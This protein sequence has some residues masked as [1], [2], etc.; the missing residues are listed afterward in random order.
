MP[1]PSLSALGFGGVFLDAKEPVAL[2]DWHDTHLGLA[3]TCWEAPTTP[4][5]PFTNPEGNRLERNQ[6]LM[7][8]GTL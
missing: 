3:F 1:T 2:K 6:P 4:G 5:F 8:P 7:K